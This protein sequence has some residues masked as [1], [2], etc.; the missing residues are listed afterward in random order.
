MSDLLHLTLKAARDKLRAKEISSVELTKSYLGRMEA[1]TALNAYITS[2]PEKALA[3]AEASDAKLATGAGGPME[4]LPIGMKDLLCTEG[5]QTTAGSHILGGL[6]PTYESTVSAKL[7][8]DGAVMLG[9]T[10]MD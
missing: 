9:K 4:G 8:R 1:T 10:N 6:T 7:W 5:V 3:M 2:T